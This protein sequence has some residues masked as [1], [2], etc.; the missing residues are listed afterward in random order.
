MIASRDSKGRFIKG[1]VPW[2][3]RVASS[4]REMT[5]FGDRKVIGGGLLKLARVQVICSA[6]GQQVEAVARAGQ[7]KGYCAVAK[8]HVDFPIETQ[9]L[10]K[11]F[12]AEHRAKISAALIR[13]NAER[14]A[15]ERPG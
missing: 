12:S 15:S 14:G 11:N 7:V 9:P 3:K 13:Y 8:Q 1:N 10:A 2:N 4:Q 5:T 6:C